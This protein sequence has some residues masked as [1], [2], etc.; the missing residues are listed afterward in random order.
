MKKYLLAVASVVLVACATTPNISESDYIGLTVEQAEQKAAQENTRFR[1][2]MRDGESLPATMDFVPGR[3]NAEVS[4]GI[5]TDYTVEG[6]G[7]DEPVPSE[8]DYIGLSVEQAEQKAEQENTRFRV[9]MRDGE[10]LPA[11]MDFVLGRINAEVSNG[12]VTGYDVEGEANN[13]PVTYDE[14]SWRTIIDDSCMSF[15]DG[16]NT[17][18]RN[19]DDGLIAA[20]TEMFCNEYQKPECL[21]E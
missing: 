11:T 3:I 1:V 20:C 9:I 7:T 10:S 4:S 2:V 19:A 17:C 12:I 21:D 13:E 5:V 14:N 18:Y 16:C 15:F 8:S 6:E